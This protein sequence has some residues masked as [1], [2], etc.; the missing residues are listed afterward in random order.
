MTVTELL[1]QISGGYNMKQNQ[2]FIVKFDRIYEHK[3]K[4]SFVENY[5]HNICKLNY[6][7]FQIYY[8]EIELDNIDVYQHLFLMSSI[9]INFFLQR[10]QLINLL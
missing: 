6:E 2:L 3:L 1:W 7:Y 4:S 8:G 9:W 5:Y 10:C